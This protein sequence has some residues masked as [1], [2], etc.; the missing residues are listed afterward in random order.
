MESS[1]R[2]RWKRDYGRKL[3]VMS[4][5]VPHDGVYKLYGITRGLFSKGVGEGFEEEESKELIA[6]FSTERLAKT[7]VKKRMLKNPIPDRGHQPGRMFRMN[8]DL[9]YY[10][11]YEIEQDYII[12]VPHDPE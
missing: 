8:T 2:S 12:E 4:E 3:F 11:D 6:T 1:H 9:E 10:Q 7:Y 5:S